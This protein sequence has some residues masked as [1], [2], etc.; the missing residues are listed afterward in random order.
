M[1]TVFGLMR[2]PTCFLPWDAA[3]Y[4][5]GRR[6]IWQRW[7][8]S[9]VCTTN[10]DDGQASCEIAKRKKRDW[11]AKVMTPFQNYDSPFHLADALSGHP[12]L[13]LLPT[14]VVWYC[15]QWR[16]N[17]L[18]FSYLLLC[19]QGREVVWRLDSKLMNPEQKIENPNNQNV[20]FFI[21]QLWKD[22]LNWREAC[23]LFSFSLSQ[24]TKIVKSTI[25]IHCRRVCVKFNNTA[26]ATNA[27]G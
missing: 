20:L 23:S 4:T 13:L 6:T 10:R 1:L 2:L 22:L 25:P 17:L 5:A 21:S 19:L 27:V 8:A 15:Y 12:L 14:D 7:E 3:L 26:A 16:R 11:H 9:R 18:D 24:C